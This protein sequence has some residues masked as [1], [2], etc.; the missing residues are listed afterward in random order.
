MAGSSNRSP[1]PRW[2]KLLENELNAPLLEVR[3]VSDRGLDH[4]FSRGHRQKPQ[5]QHTT[6]F[7]FTLVR[8]LLT[9]RYETNAVYYSPPR[10]DEFGNVYEARSRPD[11]RGDWRNLKDK[12]LFKHGFGQFE[13][14][15]HGYL[16]RTYG[17]T[18]SDFLNDPANAP[19]TQKFFGHTDKVSPRFARVLKLV[20]QDIRISPIRRGFAV[21]QAREI[22]GT[23][24]L[25]LHALGDAIDIDAALNPHILER[26][27]ID[28]VR[29]VTGKDL[30]TY[31]KRSELRLAS[32]L[33]R[34]NFHR[35]VGDLEARLR[36]VNLAISA[37]PGGDKQFLAERKNLRGLLGTINADLNSPNS[38]FRSWAANGFFNLPDALIDSFLKADR[39]VVWGGEYRTSKDFM[40]FEYDPA[41]RRQIDAHR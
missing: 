20:E 17:R 40:H 39:N 35:A 3:G 19:V 6:G 11:I 2:L 4:D 33:F 28:V 26:P 14:L 31:L 37:S 21:W 29:A 34:Q 41:R 15:Y 16:D 27:E 5:K 36:A 25:S 13:Q 10:T 30:G 12:G 9:D 18:P 7:G 1:N 22:A 32:D 24:R 23:S 38:N 8:P